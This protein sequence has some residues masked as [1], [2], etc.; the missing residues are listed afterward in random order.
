ML[1]SKLSSYK[2][3]NWVSKLSLHIFKIDYK[4]E[5]VKYI[6]SFV[7]TAL[8]ASVLLV[9]P[10]PYHSMTGWADQTQVL[11]DLKKAVSVPADGEIGLT[12][13]GPGW[14]ALAKAAHDV[15][16]IDLESS[17][18]FINRLSYLAAVFIFS[19]FIFT[20][21]G[22]KKKSLTDY[23]GALV[24]IATFFLSVNFTYFSTIPW[25]HFI[26]LPF[27]TLVIFLLCSY[28]SHKFYHYILI[29]M[30][31]GFL[32]TIR[33]FSAQA[34]L[35]AVGVW[36]VYL[37]WRKKQTFRYVL[38]TGVRIFAFSLL[39]FVLGYLINSLILGEVI[40]YRQYAGMTPYP[41]SELYGLRITD[42][43]V[44]FVQLF[45]DPCFLTDCSLNQWHK[46]TMFIVKD[47][48]NSWAYPLVL[49]IPIIGWVVFSWFI[50]IAFYWRQIPEILEDPVVAIALL[51]AGAIILGYSTALLAGADRLKFGYVRDFMDSTFFLTMATVRALTLFYERNRPNTTKRIRLLII[52]A[53]PIIAIAMLQIGIKGDNFIK[54]SSYAIQKIGAEV[55]CNNLEC[56]LQPYYI[57]S[58]GRHEFPSF[59]D[60]VVMKTT[61]AEGGKSVFW[62][63]RASEYVYKRNQCDKGSTVV[64]IPTITSASTR[65]VGPGY[66]G[67]YGGKVRLDWYPDYQLGKE[68]IF[69][70]SGNSA[71][72]VDIES[73]WS[74]TEVKHRWTDG[75]RAS[76]SMSVDSLKSLVLT[77][78]LAG[79]VR[80]DNPVVYV[81]VMIEG[82]SVGRW[83]IDSGLSQ[84]Y[85]VV[86][87]SEV[88]PQDG[89]LDIEFVIK[90][91]VSP[92]SLGE[93]LDSRALGLAFYS[94]SIVLNQSIG[95]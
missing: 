7:V 32:A 82:V 37:L 14:L 60:D 15:L 28:R 73:D 54:F 36:F 56:Y 93:S 1:K 79:F 45:I 76:L 31:I 21:T 41:L 22:G 63:G 72:Y 12:W 94:M 86:I 17:L 55:D 84:E 2:R 58:T 75:K 4:T 59:M 20:Q 81:D 89:R 52:S 18:I 43:P 13:A 78:E 19:L 77:A 16:S 29:G 5:Y 61:C 10:E 33:M 3:S 68:V 51:A 85:S 38:N 87:P 39:G 25:S 70:L 44:K 57:S 83:I 49:Q 91:P 27:S 35:A 9:L 42:F 50:Y 92:L 65:I 95:E 24:L 53:A 40:I 80:K 69:G 6:F 71:Q 34:I 67:L 47:G 74:V 62:Y 64:F 23:S 11:T 90:D 26:A 48:L 66:D 8:V 46:E 30:L 88:M